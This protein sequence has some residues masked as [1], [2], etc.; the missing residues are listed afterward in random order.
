MKSGRERGS[1]T[2][3]QKAKNMFKQSKVVTWCMR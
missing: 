2:C 3:M 1:N